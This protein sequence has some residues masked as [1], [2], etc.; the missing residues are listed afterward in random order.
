MDLKKKA[1]F[2]CRAEKHSKAAIALHS[3]IP[4]NP[5]G[6]QTQLDCGWEPPV[7]SGMSPPHFG[8]H[9]GLQDGKEGKNRMESD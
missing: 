2:I 6:S 8:G 9:F 5:S 3:P 7:K 4:D 1:R